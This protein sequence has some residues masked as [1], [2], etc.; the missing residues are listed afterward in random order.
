MKETTPPSN[1]IDRNI[2]RG[3]E[4][5]RGN[6]DKQKGMKLQQ[7]VCVLVSNAA[8]VTIYSSQQK[9]K[10]TSP[11]LQSCESQKWCTLLLDN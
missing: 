2:M 5:R 1:H 4:H 3:V 10:Q 11:S 6:P 9:Q 7:K 8:A